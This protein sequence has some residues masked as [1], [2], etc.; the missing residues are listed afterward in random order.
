MDGDVQTEKRKRRR[1]HEVRRKE[2]KQAGVG[3]AKPLRSTD[4]KTCGPIGASADE[5]RTSVA[6]DSAAVDFTKRAG[7]DRLPANAWNREPNDEVPPGIRLDLL[8]HVRELLGFD[9]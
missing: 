6:A 5:P 2:R 9:Q 4:G 1:G 8:T 7:Y 3:N